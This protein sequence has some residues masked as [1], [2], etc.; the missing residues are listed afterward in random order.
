MPIYGEVENYSQIK[1]CN[2]NNTQKQGKR[3]AINTSYSA[4]V[5]KATVLSC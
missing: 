3:F 2:S 1:Y 4:F 5:K